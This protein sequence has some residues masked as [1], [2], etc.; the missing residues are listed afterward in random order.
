[1]YEVDRKYDKEKKLNILPMIWN[2]MTKPT[3]CIRILGMEYI[4][5]ILRTLLR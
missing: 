5:V 1:M 3:K 2:I 4:I